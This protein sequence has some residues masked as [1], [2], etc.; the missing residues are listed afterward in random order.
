MLSPSLETVRLFIHVLAAGI[1]VGG[2]FVLAGIVP[3]LRKIGPEATKAAAQGFAKVAWPA[4]VLALV[5]GIWNVLALGTDLSTSYNVTLGIKFLLVIAAGASAAAHAG[6]NSKVI[7]G[8]TGG[9]GA[10]LG[11]AMLFFGSLLAHGG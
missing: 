9:L 5:T 6:S 8:L 11:I 4:F 10:V 7:K 3:G 1:W 2:Q